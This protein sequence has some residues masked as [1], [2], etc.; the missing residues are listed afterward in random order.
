MADIEQKVGEPEAGWSRKRSRC[1]I[2]TASG[3]RRFAPTCARPRI[4]SPICA[5]RPIA[6]RAATREARKALEAIH[7]EVSELEVA[8][9]TEES[10]LAHLAQSCVDTLQQTLDEVVAEVQAAAA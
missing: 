6:S 5:S 1:S 3:S 2:A 10:H 8:R 7:T 9:A 4:R